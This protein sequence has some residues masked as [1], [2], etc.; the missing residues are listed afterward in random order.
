MRIHCLHLT[1]IYRCTVQSYKQ[2]VKRL[3]VL[4]AAAV[5]Q[6]GAL[7]TNVQDITEIGHGQHLSHILFALSVDECCTVTTCNLFSNRSTE[8]ANGKYTS[9]RQYSSAG[10][11][12][13][14]DFSKPPLMA[15]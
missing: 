15:E 4:Q 6:R 10:L 12:K 1:Q 2:Q 11:L 14:T 9:C 5:L 3:A 7:L 13:C 8:D